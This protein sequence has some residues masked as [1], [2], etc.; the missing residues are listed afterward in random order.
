MVIYEVEF[1]VT[2][3]AYVFVIVML[4]HLSRIFFV[5]LLLF[6]LFCDGSLGL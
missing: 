4:S 1:I 6:S 3:K 5:L 2:R